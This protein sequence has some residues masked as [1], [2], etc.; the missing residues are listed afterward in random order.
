MTSYDD[1]CFLLHN[2]YFSNKNRK[3][4]LSQRRPC[5]APSIWVLWSIWR[6]LTT[7]T[8]TFHE[9]CKGLLFRSILR[10]CV[11]NMKCAALPVPEIIA[12]NQKIWAAPWIR[13]CFLFFTRS[14]DVVVKFDMYRNVQRHRVVIPAIVWLSK[15]TIIH[16]S[17]QN[18]RVKYIYLLP[19]NSLF[20]SHCLRYKYI[21]PDVVFIEVHD[22]WASRERRA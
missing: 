11:Q 17:R 13:P 20:D 9:I 1:G 15:W 8:A 3:A 14:H 4:E 18:N 7:P 22:Q 10:M 5:D 21:V 19:L 16:K 6:V 12:R 2:G